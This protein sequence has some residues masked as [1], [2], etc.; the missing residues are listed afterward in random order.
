MNLNENDFIRQ[1]QAAVERMR[2][3]NS[4]SAYTANINQPMPPV[5]P[6]VKVNGATPTPDRRNND[7]QHT[8]QTNGQ[9]TSMPMPPLKSDK[10]ENKPLP[11]PVFDNQNPPKNNSLFEG[12]N[13]PFLD[14]I[15]KDRDMTLIIGLLLLLLGEKADKKLLFALIYILL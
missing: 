9:N 3:L 11:P 6:F 4:R 14:K 5:P 7:N 15:K 13:L 10:T 2:E 12:L 8:T 1:Q